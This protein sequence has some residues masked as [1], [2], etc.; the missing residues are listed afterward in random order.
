MIL[1]VSAKNF[2]GRSFNYGLGELTAITGDNGAGK[3]SVLKAIQ[4]ILLGS[5]PSD[6]IN[7]IEGDRFAYYCGADS[8]IMEISVTS[9]N[10]TITKKWKKYQGEVTTQTEFG[11]AKTPARFDAQTALGVKLFNVQEFWELTPSQQIDKICLLAGIDPVALG[12]INETLERLGT[13]RKEEVRSLEVE[14][15]V[16]EGYS[17]KIQDIVNT[18]ILNENI[19]V[20]DAKAQLLAQDSEMRSLSAEIEK[21]K[22]TNSDIEDYSHKLTSYGDNIASIGA[23]LESLAVPSGVDANE[24][25]KSF[26]AMEM[27]RQSLASKAKIEN[28]IKELS[29]KTEPVSP[30]N[31]KIISDLQE[32]IINAE[33]GR[34]VTQE[35][36]IK[37]SAFQEF[38]KKL[39]EWEKSEGLELSI[40]KAKFK[41][42]AAPLKA[43]IAKSEDLSA[44]G[45]VSKW[46]EQIKAL[47]AENQLYLAKKS[48]FDYNRK[49][50]AQLKF[51]LGTI[52][53]TQ[54]D[55]EK[56]R[57][58]IIDLQLAKQAN[59]A[60]KAQEQLRDGLRASSAKYSAKMLSIRAELVKLSPVNIADLENK[61]KLAEELKGKI[62]PKYELINSYSTMFDTRESS[63]KKVEVLKEKIAKISASETKAQNEKLRLLNVVQEKIA[64]A[65]SSI[66]KPAQIEIEIPTITKRNKSEK[67]K[68]WYVKAN[69]E[70]VEQ[71][72]LSGAQKAE[73]NV[74]LGYALTGNEGVVVAEIDSLTGE[75]AL[76]LVEKIQ[77]LSAGFKMQTVLV[78]HSIKQLKELGI[79]FIEVK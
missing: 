21:G 8:G 71:A 35:D 60:K 10:G 58:T 65:C 4:L 7:K 11:G 49:E 44:I 76:K 33:A 25:E 5:V 79:T 70:R 42:Y 45:E 51:D 75:N 39:L 28:K 26:N 14:C 36:K 3:T 56:Y 30:D 50:L 6:E 20:E 41:E 9:E 23:Q 19:N 40:L 73:F 62:Q 47:K 78:G 54:F 2:Q 37:F 66:T 13:Q 72:T 31:E 64:Q 15:K 29:S 46:R 52:N 53:Y 59:E 63:I 57:K 61:Y 32:K 43:I 1:A 34:G 74:A 18:G 55:E 22:R 38:F 17:K 67:I 12:D 24:L 16:I 77:G 68:F 27:A 48:E 69:G